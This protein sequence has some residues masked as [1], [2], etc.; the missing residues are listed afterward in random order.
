LATFQKTAAKAFQKHNTRAHIYTQITTKM[1]AYNSAASAAAA[2]AVAAVYKT[3][4]V[5]RSAARGAAP[6]FV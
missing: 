5:A 2:A 3:A 1:A 6:S 4:R